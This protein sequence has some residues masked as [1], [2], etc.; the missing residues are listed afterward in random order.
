MSEN[1]I[2]WGFWHPYKMK[3]NIRE[4]NWAYSTYPL[5]TCSLLFSDCTHSYWKGKGKERR[6]NGSLSI[7]LFRHCSFQIEALGAEHVRYVL[8]FN[9]AMYKKALLD[10]LQNYCFAA[11]SLQ[12]IVIAK[13]FNEHVLSVRKF[14]DR[15]VKL[16]SIKMLIKK[17]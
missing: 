11:N 7:W 13:G 5:T 4:N 8:V 3:Y 14:E 1:L 12:Q 6:R 16:R 17:G 15:S 2:M 9:G 10:Y